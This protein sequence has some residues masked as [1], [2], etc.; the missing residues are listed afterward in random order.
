MAAETLT[1]L[2]DSLTQAYS[3][4]FEELFTRKIKPDSPI[5]TIYGYLQSIGAI[6][7]G[8]LDMTGMGGG[9]D[10][11]ARIVV[12]TSTGNSVTPYVSGDLRPA[13]G[14]RSYD[15]AEW[16]WRN[17]WVT[18]HMRGDAY[19][20]ATAGARYNNVDAWAEKMEDGFMD[21]KDQ[22]ET[23]LAG[24]GGSNRIDGLDAIFNDANTYAGIDRTSV[25]GWKPY[26]KD[27]GSATITKAML[28]DVD[29]V[30]RDTRRVNYDHILVPLKQDQKLGDLVDARRRDVSDILPGALLYKGRRI[31][32]LGGLTDSHA[33]FV[34]S[35]Q[36]F[37]RFQPFRAGALNGA[38]MQPSNMDGIPFGLIAEDDGSDGVAVTMAVSLNVGYR[39][40]WRAAYIDALG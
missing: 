25:A 8:Q 34:D 14:S 4:R 16:E 17:Y 22:I 31:I 9:G 1:I 12:K 6:G 33:F 3:S 15:T 29:L 38:L 36:F 27:A 5:D 35:R 7:V 13:G 10:K 39:N 18:M 40:T 32:P 23:D 19:R 26:K 21:L 20:A 24:S 37:L 30:L 2:Q 11:A 28:D